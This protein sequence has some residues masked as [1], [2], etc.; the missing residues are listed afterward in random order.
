VAA[1]L[2]A[3]VKSRWHITREDVAMVTG[4]DSLWNLVPLSF[5]PGLH[6]LGAARTSRIS[7]LVLPLS[8]A[9]SLNA[10]LQQAPQGVRDLY[11]GIEI[12]GFETMREV[13][14]DR[15][16]GLTLPIERR[17]SRSSGTTTTCES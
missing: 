9:N 8:V 13:L 14:N 17:T 10:L 15:R 12:L 2:G 11:Q 5:P 1:F 7:V 4:L 6:W 16:V 3:I